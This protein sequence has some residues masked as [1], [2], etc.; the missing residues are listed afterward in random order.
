MEFTL[1]ALY[2]ADA[3]ANFQ[4]NRFAHLSKVGVDEGG[5]GG[6]EGGGGD[7]MTKGNLLKGS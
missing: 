4:Q 2:L 5:G 3:R 1:L 7:K 6:G